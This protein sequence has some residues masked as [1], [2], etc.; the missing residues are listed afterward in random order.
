MLDLS[1]PERIGGLPSIQTTSNHVGV[2]QNFCLATVNITVNFRTSRFVGPDLRF[3]NFA[4]LS[5]VQLSH[6]QG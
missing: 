5:Y 4:S 6:L 2:L 1:E 3:G